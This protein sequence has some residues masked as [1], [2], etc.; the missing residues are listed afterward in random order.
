MSTVIASCSLPPDT[1][2]VDTFPWGPLPAV[3]LMRAMPSPDGYF[4]LLLYDT[5]LPA[6][7]TWLESYSSRSSS[8]RKFG[9]G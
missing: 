1:N 8:W 6:T 9:L 7:H 4:Q 2:S 3:S 5:G